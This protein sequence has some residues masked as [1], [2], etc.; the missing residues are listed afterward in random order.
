MHS[1]GYDA[2]RIGMRNPVLTAR[3]EAGMTQAELAK[4]LDV[5][6]DTIRRTE[7]GEFTPRPKTL[8]ALGLELGIPVEAII[9]AKKPKQ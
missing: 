3:E 8:I 1:A 9:A 6:V 4:K 2:L 5:S 7:Q